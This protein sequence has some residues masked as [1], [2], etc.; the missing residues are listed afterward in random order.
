ML[1]AE[2]AR[3]LVDFGKHVL[4]VAPTSAALLETMPEV[5]P[6]PV[7]KKSEDDVYDDFDEDDSFDLEVPADVEVPSDDQTV[8]DDDS[9]RLSVAPRGQEVLSVSFYPQKNHL[10]G[11]KDTPYLIYQF[12]SKEY[13]KPSI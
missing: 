4:V 1:Q 3:L 10:Q 6:L 9:G 2:L 7:L 5:V 8:L 12:S 11:E 13:F